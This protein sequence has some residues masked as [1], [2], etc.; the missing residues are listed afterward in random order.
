MGGESPNGIPPAMPITEKVT[1]T[2]G[3]KDGDYTQILSGISEGDKVMIGEL[4]VP[5]FDFG[6][7]PF[8]GG[9]DE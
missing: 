7:G 5:T 3:L 2:I 1:V 9:G 4:A 8:G 6:G